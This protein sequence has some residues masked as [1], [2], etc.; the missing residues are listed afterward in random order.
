MTKA[1]ERI[2]NQIKRELP[3]FDFY[4]ED[5]YEIKKFE[6]TP[7]EGCEII[8]VYI[9]TGM[10]NDEGTLAEALCRKHRHFFVGVRGGIETAYY[11][12]NH[13]K[14]SFRRVTPFELLN[15][16]YTD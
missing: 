5:G 10:K 8:S 6:V 3:R 7:L 1:Q 13:V 4:S 15:R 9:E 12:G 2:I 16:G 14:G 11:N